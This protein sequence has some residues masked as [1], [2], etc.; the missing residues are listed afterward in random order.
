MYPQP[1]HGKYWTSPGCRGMLL[2]GRLVEI[3]A[4]AAVRH[5]MATARAHTTSYPCRLWAASVDMGPWLVMNA[6]K[7]ASGG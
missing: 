5:P 7:A 3:V 2:T 4:L 6:N 1:P